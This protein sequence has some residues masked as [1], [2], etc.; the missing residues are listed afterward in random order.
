MTDRLE[1]DAELVLRVG[2]NLAT[3]AYVASQ[4]ERLPAHVRLNLS[5]AYQQWE[6]ARQERNR[7]AREANIA[8]RQRDLLMQAWQALKAGQPFPSTLWREIGIQLGEVT[9]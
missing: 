7:A 4:D 9:P 8:K 5:A 2:A 6:D 3:A 1:T